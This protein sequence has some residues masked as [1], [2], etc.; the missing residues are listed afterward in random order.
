MSALVRT[1]TNS[2]FKKKRKFSKSPSKALVAAVAK[3]IERKEETKIFDDAE[4][5]QETIDDYSAPSMLETVLEI[6]QGNTFE[7]R[8]GNKIFVDRILVKCRFSTSISQAYPG[9]SVAVVED[10]EPSARGADT[11]AQL[12]DKCFKNTASAVTNMMALP[13]PGYNSRFRVKKF[14]YLPLNPG[15]SYYDTAAANPRWT[16]VTQHV[17]L[18][19]PVNKVI[20]YESNATG[21]PI[22][23]STYYVFAWSDTNSNTTKVDAVSRVYFKDA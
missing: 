7:T 20:S 14:M 1:K 12:W 22:G 9:I 17:T 15:G 6:P 10:L 11:K 2:H 4:W 19:I 8:V 3:Q 23:G 18:K 16:P 5:N 21:Q 13:R